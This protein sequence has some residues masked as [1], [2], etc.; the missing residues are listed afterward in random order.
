MKTKPTL[1]IPPL[2]AALALATVASGADP[3]GTAFTYQGRLKDGCTPANGLYDFTFRLHNSDGA[4][5]GPLRALEA[6]GVTNGLFTTRIDFGPGMFDGQARWLGISV[7]TNDAGTPEELLPRQELTPTPYALMVPDGAIST[8]KLADEAVT[9]FKVQDGQIMTDDLAAGA[10]NSEKI[11]NEQ[12]LTEDLANDAVT[13]L[14]IRDG[15]VKTDDLDDGAVTLPKVGAAGTPATD[16]V[17]GYNGS[18]LAW[19]TISGGGVGTAW[20]LDGN[21]VGGPGKFLGTHDAFPLHLKVNDVLALS[22]ELNAGKITPNVIGGHEENWVASDVE[23]ATI[24]GGGWALGDSHLPN[25]VGADFGT[26]GGGWTNTL[27]ANSAT[28]GGGFGNTIASGASYGVIG[29]GFTNAVSDNAIYATIGGGGANVIAHGAASSTVAGGLGN[30]VQSS[31]SAS[32]I[33]GGTYNQVGTDALNAT[34]AG[35]NGNRV[36]ASATRA[37]I[38]GG[39]N[40]RVGQSAA[41]ATVAGGIGNHVQPQAVVSAIGGGTNNLIQTGAAA[42]TIAGGSDNTVGTNALRST[43][44]GGAGNKIDN[45]AVNCTVGGGN[46]NR[47]QT[48]VYHAT[49][50]GGANNVIRFL[51]ASSTI[52]GGMSNAVEVSASAATVGGGQGNLAGASWSTVGGGVNNRANG[53]ASSVGGGNLNIASGGDATIA[54]GRGNTASYVG[55]SVGGG[56]D[57]KNNGD[58][59]TIGGGSNNVVFAGVSFAT[60]P[61]GLQGAATNYGQQAYASGAFYTPGDAQ[62]SLYVVRGFVTNGVSGTTNEL[63]LDGVSQQMK[64][65]RNSTWTFEVLVTGRSAVGAGAGFRLQGVIENQAGVVRLI[66]DVVATPVMTKS[67]LAGASATAQADDAHDALVIKVFTPAFT[68]AK[69]V[70]AVRT[71]E[72][73]H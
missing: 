5:V 39:D 29:G 60:I 51:A 42:S 15:E 68:S 71:A 55:T 8:P 30:T 54:G 64:L 20:L 57:N 19:K 40:N 41:A 43:I 2:L 52:G 7:C 22:L 27:A 31:A 6:V 11:A 59:A 61:G 37:A 21:T 65:R 44:G 18:A 63:F 34:I 26:I 62:A 28:I 58:Y 67:E 17:L 33:A 49:I 38:G 24:G 50:G 13:S 66:E 25:A 14:K 48:N 9:T 70:A 12:V 45:A 56:T 73:I 69:W 53:L 47:I 16:K 46:L 10:V 3:M 35:G 36:E 32:T 72:V 23:G 4:T 1:T